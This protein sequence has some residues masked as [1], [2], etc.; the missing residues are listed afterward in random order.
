MLKYIKLFFYICNFT[1]CACGQRADHTLTSRVV[2][3]QTARKLRSQAAPVGSKSG[4]VL[5]GLRAD[6]IAD[7]A[8]SALSNREECATCCWSAASLSAMGD[9]LHGTPRR[10]SISRKNGVVP[11]GNDAISPRETMTKL[12]CGIADLLI[13]G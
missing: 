9:F 7:L 12:R 11:A 10:L 8:W 3:A 1:V 5:R 4:R 2:C 6:N 13:R